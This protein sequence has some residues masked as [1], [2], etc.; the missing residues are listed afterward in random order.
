LEKREKEGRRGEKEEERR[1]RMRER[2]IET[3]NFRSASFPL[4]LLDDFALAC[5]SF[6]AKKFAG[7]LCLF[8]PI[9]AWLCLINRFVFN[10]RPSQNPPLGLL[11]LY[12]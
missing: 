11:C 9:K 12:K 7:L 4:L 1:S 6:A 5:R 8:V 10:C 3:L 2:E